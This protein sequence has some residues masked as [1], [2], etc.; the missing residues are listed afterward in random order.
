MIEY[1]WFL[2][3]TS[4]FIEANSVPYLLTIWGSSPENWFRIEHLSFILGWIGYI[5]WFGRKK[6]P[7]GLLFASRWRDGRDSWW[8]HCDYRLLKI[9]HEIRG[10]QKKQSLLLYDTWECGVDV[11]QLTF[12]LAKLTPSLWTLFHPRTSIESMYDAKKAV[13]LQLWFSILREFRHLG[14]P[15]R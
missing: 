13:L 14:F 8:H 6:S 2:T 1:A 15:K 4:P 11:N 10:M 12:D 7:F 5:V 3:P 9:K